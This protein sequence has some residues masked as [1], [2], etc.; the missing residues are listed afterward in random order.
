[1]RSNRSELSIYHKTSRQQ[2][3]FCLHDNLSRLISTPSINDLDDFR[4]KNNH[5]FFLHSQ[6]DKLS[7]HNKANNHD[8]S[9]RLY[10]SR[11]NLNTPPNTRNLNI[12][13]LQHKL[14]HHHLVPPIRLEM[15]H[16][17]CRN[18]DIS[19]YDHNCDINSN[20]DP[21]QYHST[22]NWSNYYL[23]DTC[24]NRSSITIQ[25]N[26]PSSSG[27]CC[28]GTE[29]GWEDGCCCGY[30]CFLLVRGIWWGEKEGKTRGEVLSIM[31]PN[32][33]VI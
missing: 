20:C 9:Q 1:M 12:N 10:L 17:V 33:N 4:N 7:L 14:L 21:S 16:W 22:W 29:G 2:H 5:D 28:C 30:C 26:L 25:D 32:H 31:E 3:S 8:F 6:R 15:S 24:W 23:S 18:Y 19:V 27:L 11:S 13:N